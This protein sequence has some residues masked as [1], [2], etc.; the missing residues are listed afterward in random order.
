MT[1][2]TPGRAVAEPTATAAIVTARRRLPSIWIWVLGRL[3]ACVVVLLGVSIIVFAATTILPGDPARLILGPQATQSQIDAVQ[4]ELG[5]NRPPIEQYFSW[6]TSLLSGDFGTSFS[7][8]QPVGEMIL[9]RGGNTLAL[10]VLSG[11]LAIVIALVLGVVGAVQ[12]DRMSDRITQTVLIVITSLPE[13]VIG[14]FVLI[15]LSTTV[16]R[17]F[18]AVPVIPS[19]ETAWTHLDQLVLPVLTLVLTVTP[20]LAR[21]QRGTMIEVLDSE[22]V[23]M[24]R[25][26]GVTEHRLVW[27][28][29]LRNSWA[30]FIQGSSV[31]LIY[32]VGG[33]VTIEFL[34]AYPGLGSALTAAVLSRDLPSVQAI[35]IVFATAYVLLNVAADVLTLVVSPHARTQFR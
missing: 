27:R 1:I 34:F 5:L 3:G 35:V 15:L 20:Y 17:V 22:Y 2:H 30:P 21:L 32:L 12:R 28:H 24:A 19:G 14:L 11:S 29:A 4:Q 9:Q 26:K 6:L 8:K 33:V 18:P 10:V 31:T 25:L 23:R 7:S 13:F 16:L